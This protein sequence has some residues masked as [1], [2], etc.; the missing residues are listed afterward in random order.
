MEVESSINEIQ[1]HLIAFILLVISRFAG[2]KY[3]LSIFQALR[4]VFAAIE[5]HMNVI[6]LRVL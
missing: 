3:L 1:T 2:F 6:E 4:L 5:R